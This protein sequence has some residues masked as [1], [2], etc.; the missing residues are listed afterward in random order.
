MPISVVLADDHKMIRECLGAQLSQ[1]QDIQVVAY[2]SDGG[3]AITLARAWKPNIVLMDVCMPRVDG[4]EACLRIVKDL[5]RTRVIALS[6]QG[7]RAFVSQ[8][9]EA[10]VQGYVIKD[11]ALKVL[12]E[13][14]RTVAAGGSW[15]P[16]PSELLSGPEKRLLSRRERLVLKE[17][18]EGK[19]A[20]DVAEE[21]GISTK[22]VDT[23][24]RRMM[25]K[26]GLDSQVDLVRY[27]VALHGHVADSV[28][29]ART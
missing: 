13:A 20:R 24:R 28:L 5:P 12:A 9:V 10:G 27:A 25:T 29:R 1:E 11:V 18:S 14:V 3:E 16:A 8:M 23:Y 4:I 15:L 19:R 22:T 2:A 7:E 6:A 26:L 21:M 17:L